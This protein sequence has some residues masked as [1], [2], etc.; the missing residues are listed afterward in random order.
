MTR[1]VAILRLPADL[2]DL[3]RIAAGLS[4]AYP[5][6]VLGDSSDPR[7]LIVEDPYTADDR[8][9]GEANRPTLSEAA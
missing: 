5:G 6:A 7:V 3:A 8:L 2:D 9:L 1:V 4:R